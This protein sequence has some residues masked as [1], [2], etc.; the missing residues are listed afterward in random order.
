MSSPSE[1]RIATRHAAPAAEEYL[2][3]VFHTVLPSNGKC[4]IWAAV[5]GRLLHHAQGGPEAGGTAVA[6]ILKGRAP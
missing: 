5:G 3:I 6:Q 4:E 2:D 1:E